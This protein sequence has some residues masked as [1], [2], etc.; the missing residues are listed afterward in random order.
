MIDSHNSHPRLVGEMIGLQL[1]CTEEVVLCT[2]EAKRAASASSRN[3]VDGHHRP[4][5]CKERKR[6]GKRKEVKGGCAANMIWFELVV[7]LGSFGMARAPFVREMRNRDRHCRM[8]SLFPLLFEAG[9]DKRTPLVVR[10]L[11]ARVLLCF[12]PNLTPPPQSR[13]CRSEVGLVDTRSEA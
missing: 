4:C 10:V 8:H 2:E 3:L 7:Y 5:L 1:Y 6:G 13:S 11:L 9:I 12:V